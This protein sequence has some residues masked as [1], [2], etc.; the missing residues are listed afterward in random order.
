MNAAN[1][2]ND[3]AALATWAAGL[4]RRHQW[5][6]DACDEFRQTLSEELRDHL[7]RGDERGEAY[8]VAFG[9]TQVGK[10]TLILELLGVAAAEM[11]RV[12][13]VLRGGRNAGH[14]STATA[15]EY[16]RSATEEWALDCGQGRQ[17]YAQDDA[18]C[19]A[20]GR[21]RKAMGARTLRADAPA[22]VWIP[23]FAFADDGGLAGRV[24]ILDLPGDDAAE[25]AEREHVQRVAEAYVRHADL[26]LLV[27]RADDL[28]FLRP[29]GLAL[30]GIED[31]QVVPSRFRIV[32][33]YSFT[34]AS[35]RRHAEALGE[36]ASLPAFR[37]RLLEQVITHDI[38]LRG[39]AARPERFMPLEIGDSWADAQR[40]RDP[41]VK[42]VGPL[43]AQAKQ[44]PSRRPTARCAKSSPSCAT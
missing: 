16:R 12:A 28:R 1:A 31:W 36:E 15:M 11:Q 21:L 41:L 9:R 30:P 23:N 14:S 10:T 38:Q 43:L 13:E 20:L 42:T 27:G 29:E 4:A 35:V 3:D 19:E 8:V 40:Q 34:P 2:A 32:T 18:M 17:A 37:E 25:D 24:R 22:I 39:E 7:P 44:E 33:T 5:A 26:V 6:L